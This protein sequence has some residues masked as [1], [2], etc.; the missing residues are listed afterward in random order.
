MDL[1]ATEKL[2]GRLL[3]KLGALACFVVAGALLVASL[4]VPL[5]AQVGTEGGAAQGSTA[6]IH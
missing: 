5:P 1:L 3:I 2:N 4:F 6:A